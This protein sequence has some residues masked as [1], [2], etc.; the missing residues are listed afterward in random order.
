MFSVL[1]F[2]AAAAVL[3]AGASI[4]GFAATAAADV[5]PGCSAADVASVETGVAGSMA[6]Y[7]FTHPDVNNFFTGI[8]GLPK[9]EAFNQTGNYLAANPVIKGEIDAIRQ[10][11]VDLRNRCNIPLNALIRSVI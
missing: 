4:F 3:G 11:A 7:L 10:P 8:Q 5:P 6:G 9:Q 1:R 2:S